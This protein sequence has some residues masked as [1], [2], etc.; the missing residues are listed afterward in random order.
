MAKMGSLVIRP[1]TV[2]ISGCR[3]EG[4]VVAVPYL[5]TMV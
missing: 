4:K 5:Q 2:K 3:V 1:T